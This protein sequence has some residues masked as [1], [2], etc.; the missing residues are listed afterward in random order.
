MEQLPPK[1]RFKKEQLVAEFLTSLG[2]LY[3]VKS[4]SDK[5]IVEG[6]WVAVIAIVELLDFF[7][8]GYP[9]PDD[10]LRE[11]RAW[12]ATAPWLRGHSRH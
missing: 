6:T 8:D 12:L 4:D 5:T 9:A 7:A 3:P 1:A 10:K 11:L 2:Q